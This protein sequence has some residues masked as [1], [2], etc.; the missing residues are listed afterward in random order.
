L[1]T[2]APP[3]I[4]LRP[5][6][7]K[8]ITVGGPGLLVMLSDTDAGNVVTGAQAG[9]Q[10]GYRLL[11]LV[12][13]LIPMLYMVQEL[14]V[15][16]GIH[17]RR[18]FGELVRERFGI[19]WAWPATI[20]LAVASIG[21]I[22]TQ[23]AGIAGIGEL[24][25]I[26]RGVSVS[27]AAVALLS[28]VAT[29]SY[30]RAERA[31]VVVGMFELAFF[32]VAW[33]AHPTL[34]A[35]ST[36]VVDLPIANGNF[37]FLV[38]AIIGAVF[39][40]WMIF[41]QQSA[42]ADK[43]LAHD[44]IGAARWDT[45]IGAVLT[46]CLTGAILIAAA[47]V[48]ARGASQGLRSVGEISKE[49]SPFLGESVGRMVFGIGV[50]GASM[51]AAVVSSLALAWGVSEFAG[52]RRCED[53]HPS[54]TKWFYG[55][56][57]AS[58]VGAALLV[59]F[60]PDLIWLALAAQ[61]VNVFLLPLVI[62]LLVALAVKALPKPLQPRGLYLWSLIGISGVVIAAGLVGAVSGP[63]LN[64]DPRPALA[65][66]VHGTKARPGMPYSEAE[67]LRSKRP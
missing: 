67:A 6:P 27:F 39:S 45:A 60:A 37:T 57:A 1:A 61:V 65:A 29:G 11:P 33:A 12:L 26:S 28:I 8:W 18:G 30:R 32:Y 46:Q 56:Y 5:T 44:E 51:V 31:L 22:V 7:L 9:A 16:L 62:I 58:I 38:A 63:K 17:T 4:E 47:A 48:L 15:R 3:K 50:L 40:P 13:L 55:V 49:L 25:G 2:Q 23:L 54:G 43:K 24:Y 21:T 53:G 35:M 34:S 52:H 64:L 10:W 59:G 14:T 20:A 41:Y 66:R 42:F 36:D 19:K